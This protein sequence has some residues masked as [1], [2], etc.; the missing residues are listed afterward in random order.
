MDCTRS[1]S[2]IPAMVDG[3]LSGFE[4]EKLISHIE[5]CEHCSDLLC[6]E[7]SFV[8]RL[9]SFGQ[10]EM[11]PAGLHKR[12]EEMLAKKSQSVESVDLK[13]EYPETKVYQHNLSDFEGR[14]STSKT[15]GRSRRVMRRVSWLV[16][17]V[18]AVLLMV[19]LIPFDHSGNGVIKALAAEHL[20]RTSSG[21]YAALR[22]SGDDRVKMESF[23]TQ[24]LGVSVRLPEKGI[25]ERKGACCAEVKGRKVGLIGCFCSKRKALITL[26]IVPANGLDVSG[27]KK[28]SLKSCEFLIGYSG[29]CNAALWKRAD[30]LYALVSSIDSKCVLE[31]AADAATR[32]DSLKVSRN[33]PEAGDAQ[34]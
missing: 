10:S 14:H 32:M 21:N 3:E 6:N 22:V 7:R 23:L 29:S 30:V 33:T 26:F 1:A 17:G 12:I 5:E 16:A 19:F 11:A 2:R 20:S 9:R 25:A 31:M 18:A 8:A 34:K 24:E 28:V 15:A 27:L 4:I 13:E